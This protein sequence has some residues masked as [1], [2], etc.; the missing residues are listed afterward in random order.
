VVEDVEVVKVIEDR[1]R[2]SIDHLVYLDPLDH[3]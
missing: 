2:R 3:L 1:Q